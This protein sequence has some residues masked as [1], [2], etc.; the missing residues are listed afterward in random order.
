MLPEHGSEWN[1]PNRATPPGCAEYYALRFSSAGQR[2]LNAMLLA[3]HRLILE[4]GDRPNDPGVARL[5]LDWWRNEIKAFEQE[6]TRHP[7]LRALHGYNLETPV[8]DTMQQVID[9][10]EVATQRPQITD[11]L[12]F[13]DSCRGD[14]GLLF[15]LLS[16]VQGAPSETSA[17][18]DAGAYCSAVRRVQHLAQRPDRLP[19]DCSASVLGTMSPA[20]RSTRLDELLAEFAITP[21]VLTLLPEVAR[22]LTACVTAT[23][24]KLQRTRYAVTDKLI[25][26]APLAQ[27]W[28]AW[29]A[30]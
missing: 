26:R 6:Q 15:K 18:Q 9:A 25:D 28:S 10:A 21:Q 13:A 29:R 17:V 3:W 19:P 12:A 22:R 20:Q 16:I 30:R 23:H 1:F 11:H 27:L 5:K 24:K 2:D 4:I 8:F 7:L 14:C